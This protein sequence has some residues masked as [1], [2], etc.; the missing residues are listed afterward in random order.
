MLKKMVEDTLS[1]YAYAATV[2]G[3]QYKLQETIYGFEVYLLHLFDIEPALIVLCE[4]YL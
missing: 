1:E 4:I 2:A 3:L